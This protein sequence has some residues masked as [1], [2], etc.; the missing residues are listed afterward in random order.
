MYFPLLALLLFFADPKPARTVEHNVIT[1]IANPAIKI[2]VADEFKYLGSFPF[3]LGRGIAAGERHVWVKADTRNRVIKLFTL[4]FE[5][6]V[7]GSPHR[8]NYSPRNVTHLGVNDYNSNGFL[9]DDSEYEKEH[10]GNEATMMHK[11]VEA[12]GYS[13]DAEQVLY[14]F[15]R[16]LPDDHRNEFLIFYIEPTKQDKE[17]EKEIVAQVRERALKAF[18]VLAD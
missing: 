2:K 18:K 9:Y 3:T 13:L 4:Q 17:R 6:Y 11:F 10:P 16:S 15:Y 5:G 14:R 12:K 7:P 1:S 8:Y